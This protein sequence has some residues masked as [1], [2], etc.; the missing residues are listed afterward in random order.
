MLLAVSNIPIEDMVA[1]IDYSRKMH[2][3]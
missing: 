1:L 2:H 3:S